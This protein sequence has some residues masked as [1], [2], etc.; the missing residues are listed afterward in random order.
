MNYADAGL[1]TFLNL[2]NPELKQPRIITEP[3]ELKLTLEKSEKRKV[4]VRVDN[5]GRGYLFGALE[6]EKPVDGLSLSQST[7]GASGNSGGKNTINYRKPSTYP[8]ESGE[9][10]KTDF[11]AT[12]TLEID[13]SL[14][15][16][17]KTYH[18]SIVIN[19]NASN[20]KT[21]IPVTISVYRKPMTSATE[22]WLITIPLAI[23]TAFTLNINFSALLFD[24]TMFATIGPYIVFGGGVLGTIIYNAFFSNS[25]NGRD[26]H[27]G[28]YLLSLLSF[29]GFSIAAYLIMYIITIILVII[30][31]AISLYILGSKK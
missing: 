11:E 23:I 5:I 9:K 26:N 13:A 1:E 3:E 19:S 10:S 20:S 29:G 2:I 28:N 14:M 21:F 7:I 25:A 30:G 12:L 6:L 18:T 22:L 16:P 27:I 31:I 17:G 8:N 15:A 24:D 4:Q